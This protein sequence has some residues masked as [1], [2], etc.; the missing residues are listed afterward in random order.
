MS[1]KKPFSVKYDWDEFDNTWE[2]SAFQ[3]HRIKINFQ[4]EIV[5]VIQDIINESVK[6]KKHRRSELNAHNDPENPFKLELGGES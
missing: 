2:L 6:D 3:K 1:R 4:K 5:G